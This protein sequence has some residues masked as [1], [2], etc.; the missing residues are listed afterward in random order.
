M[1]FSDKARWNRSLIYLST[2]QYNCSHSG[3]GSSW[4]A[5]IWYKWD[6]IGVGA[7]MVLKRTNAGA[8]CA[9]AYAGRRTPCCRCPYET[10]TGRDL[11]LVLLV[12]LS[13]L[14]M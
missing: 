13:G 7:E 12:I 9:C 5:N 4:I 6:V 11:L 3:N 2:R 14:C 10:V 1:L 8:P